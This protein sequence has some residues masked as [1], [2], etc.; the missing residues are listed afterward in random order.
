MQ[1]SVSAIWQRPRVVSAVKKPRRDVSRS[2][3]DLSENISLPISSF[4]VVILHVG[5]PIMSIFERCWLR[6][7]I[8]NTNNEA[9]GKP[10][11][12]IGWRVRTFECAEAP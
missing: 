12:P 2:R 9:K 11:E 6:K 7:Q 10:L 3:T 5:S 8:Y 1:Y 4:L